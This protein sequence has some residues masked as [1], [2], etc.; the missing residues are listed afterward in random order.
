MF[1]IV[2]FENMNEQEKDPD[3]V[4][5]TCHP[6]SLEVKAGLGVL[7]QPALYITRPN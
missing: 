3:I 6:S 5:C 4:A 1:N 7:G 2:F